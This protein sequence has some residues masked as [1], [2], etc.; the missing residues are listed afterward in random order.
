[1]VRALVEGQDVGDVSTLRNPESIGELRIAIRDWQERQRVADEQQLFEDFRYFRIHYHALATAARI[2][3]VTIN[4]PPVNALNER[5][6]DELNIVI[7]HVARR[8][9]VKVVIFTGQGTS[10]FVA[11]ADIRQL[12]EDVH[13]LEEALPLP[14]N[15]HLAFRK[16]EAMDKP[17]IAAINGVALGGGMEFAMA[18]HVRLAEPLA[19]FGQPEVRLNLLPGYGGTQRLP[20]L[21]EQAK[22]PTPLV[23]TFEIVMGGRTFDAAEMRA[24][25]LVHAVTDESED[26]LTLATRLA[27]EYVSATT[28]ENL[29][30]REFTARRTANAAWQAAGQ[31]DLDA[32][33]GD[34]EVL[35]LLAQARA[36]GRGKTAERISMRCALGGLRASLRVSPAKHNCSPKRSWT[37]RGARLAFARSSI[38]RARPCRP[39]ATR[40]RGQRCSRRSLRAVNYCRSVRR[41]F[42]ALRPYR[43]GNTD[44]R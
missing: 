10:A 12:Y 7:D 15:A 3:V 31:D 41:S 11:G 23:R 18:C 5:A 14:N 6:L 9:D 8:A 4:N 2:A 22:H 29:I 37:P 34:A 32:A 13:T 17:V 33:L 25:G 1:M 20:R 35:R 21:L 38:S 24:D 43:I 19:T 42:P 40:R 39:A 16:I 27:T 26:V 28:G 30:A 44:M 36:V